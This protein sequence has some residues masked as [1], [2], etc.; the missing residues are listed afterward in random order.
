MK[1]IQ[2][3]DLNLSDFLPI[4]QDFV[5]P[6]CQTAGR[7]KRREEQEI[8]LQCPEC[9]YRWSYIETD[10]HLDIINTLLRC[11][12][13]LGRLLQHIEKAYHQMIV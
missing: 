6:Q 7:K 1:E 10:V 5:C 12:M 2:H 11:G 13:P 3:F 9:G 8:Y 4:L